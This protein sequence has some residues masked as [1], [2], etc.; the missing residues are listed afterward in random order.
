M[1]VNL[2]VPLGSCWTV[3][4]LGTAGLGMSHLPRVATQHMRIICSRSD[5]WTLL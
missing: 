3:G 5:G 4:E 1:S 2:D